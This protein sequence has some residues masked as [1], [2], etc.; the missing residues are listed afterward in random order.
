MPILKQFYISKGMQQKY[1]ILKECFAVNKSII[2]QHKG[3]YNSIPSEELKVSE[4]LSA[5][6]IVLKALGY[7]LYTA[8]FQKRDLHKSQQ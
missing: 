2:H 4:A 1:C 5:L 7:Y 8:A 3:F 6:N